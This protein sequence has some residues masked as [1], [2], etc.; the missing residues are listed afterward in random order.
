[1]IVVMKPQAS[2]E[3][4]KHVV[5]LVND[6][7]LKENII[8]GTDRTVIA[9]I[10]DKR[11]VEKSAIENAGNVEK[12]VPILAPYKLASREVVKEKTAIRIG[13]EK[14]PLGGSKVGVIAGPCAVEDLDQV[15]KTAEKVKEAG[16]IGLRGGAFKPRTSPYSFQGMK[17]EGLEI[18]AKAREKT[19]LA[20]VTEVVSLDN[21]DAVA[22]TADVL[23]VGARN[24]QHYPLLEALGK[25][26]KPVLLKRGL[27]SR[28]DEFLLAA[29]YIIN[30]GNKQVIMCERGIRTYEEYV[31]N[32]L[33]L[34]S[35]PALNERTH[36]PI[37]VDPSHGT[38][39]SYMVAPMC[40][41]AVAA[42]AD[43]LLVECHLDPEHALSDGAQSITPNALKE[44]VQS[45]TKIAETL[46][47]SV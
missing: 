25:V 15:L 5:K 2:N 44:M 35:I 27:C 31:R 16:C 38:G 32:T 33:P 30:A 29:E 17:Y 19:G 3:D 42:G 12:V 22:Q 10:G 1:M 39:H 28:L 9:C 20:I 40:R 18:L 46:G 13:P 37:V 6:F 41:A 34:A 43:G 11:H 45:V 14:F 21:V 8:Y 23:Q 36:L 47:R 24:M 4:V 26:N 7:G